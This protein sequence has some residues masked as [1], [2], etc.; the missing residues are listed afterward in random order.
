MAKH[1]VI[2]ESFQTVPHRVYVLHFLPEIWMRRENGRAGAATA[3]FADFSGHWCRNST[4]LTAGWP[5]GYRQNPRDCQ[6]SI[7]SSWGW[8]G[9]P[10]VVFG[11][12][13]AKQSLGEELRSK[14]GLG[15]AIDRPD[16]IWM[17]TG[18]R[19]T[20]WL[21]FVIFISMHWTKACEKC[22]WSDKLP[23]VRS[24]QVLSRH[25]NLRFN[26]RYLSQSLWSIHAFPGFVSEHIGFQDINSKRYKLS[27]PTMSWMQQDYTTFFTRTGNPFI[28]HLAC[29]TLKGRRPW[30]SG[31]FLP[32]FTSLF[33]GHLKHCDVLIRERSTTQTLVICRLQWWHSRKPRHMSCRRTERETCC[34]ALS[35]IV[36]TETTPESF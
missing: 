16:I 35:K 9:F 20:Y 5:S 32:G 14:I 33:Q 22:A 30:Q 36:G 21:T 2:T 19:R 17:H 29:K 27:Q 6:R 25:Q 28:L 23:I 24:M 10:L 12:T 13:L 31:Y 18:L 34:E 1:K 26:P 15:A 4:F 8:V 3:G 11:T 7:A